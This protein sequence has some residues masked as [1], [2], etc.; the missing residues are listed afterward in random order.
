MRLPG[1]VSDESQITLQEN[2]WIPRIPLLGVLGILFVIVVWLW[3]SFIRGR[4]SL[5]IDQLGTVGV[6]VLGICVVSLLNWRLLARNSASSPDE[7]RCALSF[8]FAAFLLLAIFLPEGALGKP[9]SHLKSFLLLG[10]ALLLF[11]AIGLFAKRIAIGI[12]GLRTSSPG[13]ILFFA[14]TLYFLLTSWFTLA[15][16]RAF[17]YV[18]QDIAYF[19]QCLYTTLHGHLFYSNMYHDLLYGQPVWSD[20]A[21]HNQSVLFFLLPFYALHKSAATMLIV[22][23]VLVVLCAWPVYLIARRI[24]SPGV[25]AVAAFAFLVSPAV[26]YQN[27]YD[28]APL[29]LAAFPL[30]F[31]FYF[32]LEGNF[33]PYVLVLIITQLVREDLVFVIFGLGLLALWQRRTVRWSAIPCALAAGWA[34][35]TW[36]VVFPYFLHGATS[37]VA[38]CFGYLGHTP[39]QMLRSIVGHP[40]I[41]LSHN[42]V[43][44]TK[45]L[46]DSFG[47]ILFLLNPLWLLSTPYIAIN[48]LGQGGGCNTA[49]IYRHY[50][51]IPAAILYVSFLFSVK[52]I[53]S[54]IQARGKN[55]A[56]VQCAL[57]FFVLAASLSSTMFV[58][59]EPQFEDL[60]TR[61]WH[62]EARQLAQAIPQTASVAVPRYMLPFVANRGG[63][64]LSLRLLE[65]HHPDAQYIALDKDWARMAATDQWKENYYRL[66]DLLQRD[67]RYSVIYDSSN[68]VVYRLCEGCKTDLPHVIP[69][70]ELHE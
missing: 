60:R 65:Y 2:Q 21:G 30:L 15:K 41:V 49:I 43:I 53:G 1:G 62:A 48:L 17:G 3:A 47:G 32:Y 56:L 7:P 24:V 16:L 6:A 36:K 42:N 58:T 28:F 33:K 11:L 67:S 63:L 13:R 14:C 10:L 20:Y 38:S 35:L 69:R 12:D 19:T 22:R 40:G 26:I 34:A 50:S 31:A 52:K 39:A 44:Y 55:P 54:V 18:G 37:A 23:N 29:S 51:L 27:V 45:Q 61:S 46:I 68:Y 5:G 59:G 57:I 4:G 64:Y 25:A 70:Q 9:P 8:C 66:W